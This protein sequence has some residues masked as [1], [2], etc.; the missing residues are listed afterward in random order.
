M[1]N[2]TPPPA[3]PAP[4]PQQP[5]PPAQPSQK[6]RLRPGYL[7]ALASLAVALVMVVVVAAVGTRIG[8]PEPDFAVDVTGGGL[9]EVEVEEGDPLGE[10]V[11]ITAD[12]D[13][14]CIQGAP[15]SGLETG[16][17]IGGGLDVYGPD[18]MVARSVF[19][20]DEPGTHVFEC[21]EEVEGGLAPAA[22]TVDAAETRQQIWAVTALGVPTVAVLL[23]AGLA[24]GTFLRSRKENAPGPPPPGKPRP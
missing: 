2:H 19:L 6:R 9:I 14:T 15:E 10:M 12:H 8:H 11:L 24:L 22:T 16:R 3:P 1:S 13:G 23:A 21:G 20:L 4:G 18:E 7:A 5:P 17:F